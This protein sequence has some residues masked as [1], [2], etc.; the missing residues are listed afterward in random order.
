MTLK[1]TG[2]APGIALGR[3]QIYIKNKI[4]PVRAFV[5]AGEK[6]SHLDRYNSVKNQALNELE[7]VRLAV[8]K[9]DP[10]KA[11]IFAAHKDI[12]NDIV[13]NEEIPAKILNDL[14]SGDWAIYHVYET[15]L[16]VMR[17][18][19]NPSL[20]ERAADIEDVR[21]RLLKIW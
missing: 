15:F 13:I 19:P 18:T 16:S 9:H 3:V 5:P 4:Q 12:V 2:A 6:Q 20:A 17:Q 8:G 21:N 1:G 7:E 10:E 11:E 14:W